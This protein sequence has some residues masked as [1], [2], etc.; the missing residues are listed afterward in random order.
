MNSVL[1]YLDIDSVRFP[2]KTAITYKNEAYTFVQL[3]E[4]SM[5]IGA[6]LHKYVKGNQPVCVM[7]ERGIETLAYFLGLL[8]PSRSDYACRQASGYS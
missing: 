6:M 1:E 7:V 8:C 2:N 3:K 4:L 5:R